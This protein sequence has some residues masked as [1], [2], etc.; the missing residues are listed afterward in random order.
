[1]DATSPQDGQTATVELHS[2]SA[3]LA[4][5]R[6][7]QQLVSFPGPLKPKETHKNDVIKFCER[8][9]SEARDR[10]M[11]DR[12]SFELLWNMLILLL[13]QKGQV[14]GSDLA[15][16]LLREKRYDEDSDRTRTSS[17]RDDRKEDRL[18][19]SASSVH[20][21]DAAG[22]TRVSAS[23]SIINT[24]IA[25]EDSVGKFRSYLLHGNKQ[26]GLEYAMKVGLWG[27][28]LFLASKMDQRTY[29][30]VMTRFANG[31]AINDSLQT[32]YQLMSSRMPSAMKHCADQRWGDWR[33]H[34][35]MILSNPLPGSDIN[36]RS[37]VTL[38][39]TL[40]GR[41]QLYAAQFCYIVSAVE[42]GT[43]SKKSSKLVLLCSA[44]G[45]RSV[46][47]FA[48][49]EA[50]QCTEI[51][52]FV[53]RLGNNDFEMPTLQP[54][55]FL[56]AVRLVECGLATRAQDYCREIAEFVMKNPARLET[57]FMPDF[58]LQLQHLIDKLK[59]QD[60]QYTT[61]AGEL[62]EI[63]DPE[64]MTRFAETVQ[65]MTFTTGHGSSDVTEQE[66]VSYGNVYNEHGYTDQQM[67]YE[68]QYYQQTDQTTEAT[69]GEHGV[70]NQGYTNPEQAF[71]NGD[72]GY[73]Q[74]KYASSDMNYANVDTRTGGEMNNI[75]R[76]D[77][78]GTGASEHIPE[79]ELQENS[80]SIQ[81]F[82]TMFNP[83]NYGESLLNNVN[84]PTSE[85]PTP[86][87]V[88]SNSRR[89]SVTDNLSRKPSLVEPPPMGYPMPKQ[90]MSLPPD[91]RPPSLTEGSYSKPSEPPAPGIVQAT[92]P[93]K[94]QKPEASK[95][96]MPGKGKKSS[97]LGGIFGK[98]L[99]A[100][101]QVHLP[102]DSDKKI[103]FDEKLGR[104]V[105]E[106][107]EEDTCAPA[108]PPPMDSS[109]MQP[110]PS[111]SQTEPSMAP[112][113]PPAQSF[114]APKRRGR[115]YVD[116]FGQTGGTKPVTAPPPMLPGAELTPPS[117]QSPP[118]FNPT[119]GPI[120]DEGAPS[121]EQEDVSA[122]AP[123]QPASMPMMFNPGSMVSVSGPPAF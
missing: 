12:D 88:E 22:E 107:E 62:S 86:P 70:D 18:T 47:E 78:F 103:T 38:G 64:W 104:W 6:Q 37:M 23:R 10:K 21:E 111:V 20:S 87:V 73:E 33:P 9:M 35:A 57:D 32:L 58:L 110:A 81:T 122:A 43:F 7:H 52:E 101:N 68:Q 61:S 83:A 8:K 40:A 109:F 95:N 117:S 30:G 29:A 49:N 115:G 55:K 34:L 63:P 27:H 92:P 99:K 121:Q 113:N 77:S 39:D 59:Y 44:V 65:N 85:Q 108:A 89:S 79:P 16:L 90:T 105:N 75:G 106:G 54:F 66:T 46:D 50:I 114:R 67:G 56:H 28:A 71:T 31:L 80:A 48:T 17:H 11:M 82:P 116:V 123:S 91:P 96:D 102:D 45:E 51:Y 3:L 19:S 98:I 119:L 97:W 5:T 15:D 24:S 42:F 25:Q 69:Y 74:T 26:E 60:P 13:R 53:Q 14:E 93:Q 100:P 2:V 112:P 94:Q 4:H 84:L 76:K 72:Q 36:R 41:G 120:S 118:M 1:V